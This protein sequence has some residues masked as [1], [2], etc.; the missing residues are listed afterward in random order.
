M[1]KNET[2]HHTA[3]VWR[4]HYNRGRQRRI[5]SRLPHSGI[6][7]PPSPEL[8]ANLLMWNG[9]SNSPIPRKDIFTALLFACLMVVGSPSDSHRSGLPSILSLIVKMQ[10]KQRAILR[11][12]LDYVRKRQRPAAAHSSSSE[13]ACDRFTIHYTPLKINAATLFRKKQ[14]KVRGAVWFDS[15][16][17]LHL[18]LSF[19]ES[20]IDGKNHNH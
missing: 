15:S 5:T 8:L 10:E 14:S 4:I 16:F 11:V 13:I 12:G 18:L 20:P 6:S 19:S 3:G 1:E 9:S 2:A 17:C 7:S